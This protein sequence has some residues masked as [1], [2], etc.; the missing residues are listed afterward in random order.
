MCGFEFWV[1]FVQPHYFWRIEMKQVQLSLALLDQVKAEAKQLERSDKSKSYVEWLNVLAQKY[2]VHTFEAL[3]KKLKE[4]L[5]KDAS[6]AETLI[7]N[8]RYS[9]DGLL[10]GTLG[11]GGQDNC[12]ESMALPVTGSNVPWPHCFSENALFSPAE[13]PRSQI[14]GELKTLFG[15]TEVFYQGEQLS[16]GGDQTV[17]MAI[18]TFSGKHRCGRLLEFSVADLEASIGCK[19]SEM[20]MPLV[21]DEISRSLWRLTH[22]NLRVDD[23]EFSGPILVFSDTRKPSEKYRVRINPDFYNFF[24]PLHMLK[25]K[26]LIF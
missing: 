15:S 24:S 4:Q 12:L 11:P 21:I 13:G 16:V 14:D 8:A 26:G 25:L 22:C 7:W 18:M 1:Q 17:L 5:Q 20:G 2:G 6:K 10:W 9:E 19:F 3:N 23:F